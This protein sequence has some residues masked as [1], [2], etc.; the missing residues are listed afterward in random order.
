MFLAEGKL[1]PE[2]G[3][4]GPESGPVGTESGTEERRDRTKNVQ[5]LN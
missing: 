3:P 4:V 1:G 5:I 2:S